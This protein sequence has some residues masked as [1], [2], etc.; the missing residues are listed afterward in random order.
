M[1]V[2]YWS[3]IRARFD[4]FASPDD[5]CIGPNQIRELLIALRSPA[6]IEVEDVEECFI[7]LADGSDGSQTTPRIKPV[8]FEAWYRKYYDEFEGAQS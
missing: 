8:P 4:A 3:P 1:C 7:V 2:C 6:P 5:G